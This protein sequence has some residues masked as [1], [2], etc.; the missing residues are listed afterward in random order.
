M[1]RSSARSEAP[2]ASIDAEPA[3]NRTNASTRNKRS[4]PN[5]AGAVSV[6]MLS[7][8]TSRSNKTRVNAC[9]MPGKSFPRSNT[10]RYV[11]FDFASPPRSSSSLDARTD[12]VKLS[13]LA[14]SFSKAS[15]SL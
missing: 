15:T 11:E 2:S 1:S 7:M 9:V 3:L 10:R 13:M 8:L 5:G 6:V 14:K 4:D 12:V